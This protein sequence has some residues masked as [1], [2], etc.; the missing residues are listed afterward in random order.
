MP[1]I[2]PNN[3]LTSQ[4]PQP[5][6]VITTR[7]N[8]IRRVRTERTIPHPSLMARQ[9]ALELKRLLGM[10]TGRLAL[11]RDLGFEVLDFPDLGGAVGAAGGEVLDVGGEQDA[12]YVG[13]VGF[14]VGDG[15]EL[16][17][18]AVL[19]EVP[20]VDVALGVLARSD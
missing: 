12:G 15:D 4:L 1:I 19:E 8:Q 2:L 16:G 11:F 5:R 9:R 20:D 3:L 6:I 7:R 18:F 10:W 13:V 17:F 14:E